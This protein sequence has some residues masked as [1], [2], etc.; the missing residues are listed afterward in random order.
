MEIKLRFF[1]L[2]LPLFTVHY[3]VDNFITNGFT[4][5]KI[6]VILNLVIYC[7]LK[8]LLKIINIYKLI[9]FTNNFNWL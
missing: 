9:K 2:E 3:L 1:K 6:N 4:E 5:Y 8:R 7:I